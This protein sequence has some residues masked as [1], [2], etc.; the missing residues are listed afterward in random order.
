MFEVVC[1]KDRKQFLRSSDTECR[2]ENRSASL[3]Y[4]CHFFNEL[5]FQP[6]SYRMVF[7]RIRSFDDDGVQVL[8]I[9]WVSTIDEPG[10]LTIEVA[11]VE[12][13]F[14]FG[15]DYGLSTTRYVTCINQS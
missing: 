2:Y 8:V 15:I 12:E 13:P 3:H 6:I 7:R 9:T 14:A 10:W 1:G 5:L 11:R 4:F